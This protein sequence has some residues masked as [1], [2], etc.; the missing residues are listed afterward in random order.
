MCSINFLL[1]YL[2]TD[3]RRGMPCLPL[4]LLMSSSTLFMAMNI[5]KP[6]KATCA[7]LERRFDKMRAF[8]TFSILRNC[9]LGSL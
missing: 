1:T 9:K 5:S 3:V 6:L 2:L 7:A 4:V 8:V